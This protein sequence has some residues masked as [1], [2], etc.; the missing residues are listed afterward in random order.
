MSDGA[1]AWCGWPLHGRSDAWQAQAGA[2]RSRV[3]GPALPADRGVVSVAG[4]RRESSPSLESE[5]WP[6]RT[7]AWFLS[8]ESGASGGS[9]G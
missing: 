9:T 1:M 2:D 7:M 6:R 5:S 4:G 3:L 8:R